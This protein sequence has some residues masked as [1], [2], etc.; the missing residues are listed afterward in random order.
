MLSIAIG[1]VQSYGLPHGAIGPCQQSCLRGLEENQVAAVPAVT[2]A[3]ACHAMIVNKVVG[4]AMF[5]RNQ[6]DKEF[7]GLYAGL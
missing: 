4:L 3:R 2:R 6:V 5:S 7:R 1:I